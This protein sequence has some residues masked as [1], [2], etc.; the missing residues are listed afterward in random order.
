MQTVVRP[1]HLKAQFLEFVRFNKHH[2][3]DDG[4]N[5]S[6]YMQ[7]IEKIHL[8]CWISSRKHGPFPGEAVKSNTIC[9]STIDTSSG[10]VVL[11]M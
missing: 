3:L 10:Y 1:P 6:Y 9:F 11:H 2:P 8:R 7:V 5:E 4:E